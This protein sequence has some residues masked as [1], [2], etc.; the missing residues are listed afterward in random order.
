MALLRKFVCFL[1][2]LL[3]GRVWGS[4][5]LW[6][7]SRVTFNEIGDAEKNSGVADVI[8]VLAKVV[9]RRAMFS[10]ASSMMGFCPP[11]KELGRSF[12]RV[13]SSPSRIMTLSLRSASTCTSLKM[14]AIPHYRRWFAKP[15]RIVQCPGNA[16][17]PPWTICSPSS[18]LR[19]SS[20]CRSR[21]LTW[22][23]FYVHS[24][25]LKRGTSYMRLAAGD[26]RSRDLRPWRTLSGNAR[27]ELRKAQGEN[28]S[29]RFLDQWCES[30]TWS[31]LFQG[32]GDWATSS[33]SLRW[34]SRRTKAPRS[35]PSLLT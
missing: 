8:F 25:H 29:G 19:T 23:G 32:E 13:L 9:V 12:R 22:S 3:V 10:W 35:I 6:A 1:T 21:I 34:S 17:E 31:M 33:T 7:S 14:M 27:R 16:A 15:S 4:F 30:A 11:Y 28:A 20:T 2:R 18:L 5:I 26:N 24:E